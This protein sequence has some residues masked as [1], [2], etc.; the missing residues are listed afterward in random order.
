MAKWTKDGKNV[1]IDK[2]EITE[3]KQ[4]PKKILSP[5]LEKERVE[6]KKMSPLDK[7]SVSTHRMKGLSEDNTKPHLSF[8][9]D[10]LG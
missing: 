10:M 4:F 9:N 6:S 1:E 8:L 7:G 5:F 2:D 3:T